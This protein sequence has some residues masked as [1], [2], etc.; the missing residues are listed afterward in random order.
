MYIL[1]IFFIYVFNTF[2]A[3]NQILKFHI[4]LLILFFYFLNI[5]QISNDYL[6]IVSL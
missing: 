2:Q 5:Y 6:K 3:Y 4:I 1:G